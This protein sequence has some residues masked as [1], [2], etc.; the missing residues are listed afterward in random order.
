MG[1]LNIFI[2]SAGRRVELVKLFKK[3]AQNLNIKSNIVTGDASNDAP[4]LYFSDRS[5]QLPLVSSDLYIEKIIEVANDEK[6]SLIIPTIDTELLILS[7]NKQYIE[8]NTNAK[9]L[10]SNEEVIKIC[11]DKINTQNYMEKNGFSMPKMLNISN[12]TS[13]TEFPLFIKPKSG[14]SSIGA[15][16]V[17]NY[18]ELM[19]YSETINDPI[20]QEF[21]SG[22]EYTVDVFLDFNSNVIS[23]APRLRIETRAGEIS[24][25]KIVKDR[26]IIDTIIELMNVLK[27][28][29][30]ITVQ[31]IKTNTGIQFIE[32]NPRFG[33]GAPMSIMSG[34][35]TPEYLYKL[36]LGE[37]L[38][39]NE[40]YRQNIQFLRFDNSIGIDENLE[41]IDFD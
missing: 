10:I 3:A 9:V 36:L 11:R 27:P 25:G 14:S 16:K 34:A 26:T 19:N 23:V 21:A 17:E 12:V 30:H 5:Y 2:L 6:I 7:K 24:K 29:G 18:E 39:Y 13:D 15:Y 41:V 37:T 33:G 4:A 28:I 32:I 40:N 22:D 31:L 38:K 35:D 20:I 8:E 1:N